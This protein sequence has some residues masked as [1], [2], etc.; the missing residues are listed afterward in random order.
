LVSVTREPGTGEDGRE[1]P[2]VTDN[3]AIREGIYLG[4]RGWTWDE[5][6]PTIPELFHTPRL[7]YLAL[8]RKIN[9]GP[10]PDHLWRIEFRRVER[11]NG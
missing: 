6:D 7:A 2:A 4:S 11:D 5:S 3:E 1:L 8:F 10:M 9:P